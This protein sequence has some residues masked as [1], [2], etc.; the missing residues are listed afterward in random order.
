MDESW[1]ASSMGTSQPVGATTFYSFPA[2]GR[3]TRYL[4]RTRSAEPFGEGTP[5]LTTVTGFR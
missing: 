1:L 4:M 2:Q 3:V 5:S